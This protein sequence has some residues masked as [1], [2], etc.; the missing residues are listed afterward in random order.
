MFVL[1]PQGF[2]ID[3]AVVFGCSVIS[4]PLCIAPPQMMRPRSPMT[5]RTRRFARRPSATSA[6]VAARRGPTCRRSAHP[7]LYYLCRV[8]S[9]M[10]P[11]SSQ[12]FNANL[13]LL[14]VNRSFVHRR[15]CSSLRRRIVCIRTKCIFLFSLCLHFLF[16][17]FPSLFLFRPSLPASS[18]LFSNPTFWWR[19]CA[20]SIRNSSP[21]A[22]VSRGC[23]AT[24]SAAQT[25]LLVFPLEL[26]LRL[27]SL[28]SLVL[29]CP[30]H[31]ACPQLGFPR[32]LYLAPFAHSLLS[33]PAPVHISHVF[34]LVSVSF[35]SPFSLSLS[36][37][38][39]N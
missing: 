21:R 18:D 38:S 20:R 10:R 2:C 9:A 23:C 35:R 39:L 13:C 28:I 3:V 8:V 17:V 16:R 25:R 11:H 33:R 26:F 30:I 32:S 15:P 7:G 6:T 27:S 4:F 5:P 29:F 22:V 34:A 12:S 24:L 36:L 19:Q 14:S 1:P 31:C 37:S